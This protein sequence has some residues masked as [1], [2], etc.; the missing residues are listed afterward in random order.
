MGWECP[1]ETCTEVGRGDVQ[2]ENCPRTIFYMT[3]FA[4]AITE[5]VHGIIAD[6]EM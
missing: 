4:F 3:V 5:G 2:G 1:G 6:G